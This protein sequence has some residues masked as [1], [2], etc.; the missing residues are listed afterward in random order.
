M[1]EISLVCFPRLSISLA[2]SQWDELRVMS[3]DEIAHFVEAN[4]IESPE[5]YPMA[6]ARVSTDDLRKFRRVVVELA[7]SFGFPNSVSSHR[8]VEFDQKLSVLLHRS[9]RLMPNDAACN[10]VWIC[11]NL[12]ILPD[13]LLWR[14]GT[15]RS[16]TQGWT[17]SAER[18]YDLVRST[19]G[20]LWWRVELLGEECLARLGE[21]ECVQ[22]L[23]RPRIAGYGPLVRSIVFHHISRTIS[24][25]RMDLLREV[26][27]TLT[28]RLAVRS[29]FAMTEQQINEFVLEIFILCEDALS[30]SEQERLTV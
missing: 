7:R 10:E 25:Q 17:V 3:L 20:R 11:V 28:R 2:N 16:N 19:F 6:Q 9:M 27:K 14:H 5:Y 8:K 12:M 15:W 4:G 18:I 21:D 29:V 26:L 1:T 24:T 13:V 30:I 22:I 23:E